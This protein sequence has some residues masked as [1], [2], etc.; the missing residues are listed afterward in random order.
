MPRLRNADT[1][2][3]ADCVL[4]RPVVE[5]HVPSVEELRAG[6]QALKPGEV[7]ALVHVADAMLASHTRFV[8][9]T[10]KA[11]KLPPISFERSVASEGGLASYGADLYAVGRQSAKYGHQVLFGTSP[12]DTAAGC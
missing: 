12:A 8:V 6:V 1:P 11:K 10:A 4:S 7:D 2:G 5:W 3:S 9:D